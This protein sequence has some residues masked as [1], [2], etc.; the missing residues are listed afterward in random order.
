MG[1]GVKEFWFRR[2]GFK[3]S[4]FKGRGFRGFGFWIWRLGFEGK[5]SDVKDPLFS[6]P[7]SIFVFSILKKL[8]KQKSFFDFSILKK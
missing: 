7:F 1:I 4:G 6:T 5:S 2:S 3:G 8:K